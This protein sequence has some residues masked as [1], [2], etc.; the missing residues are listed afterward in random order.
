MNVAEF[1]LKLESEIK[2]HRVRVGFTTEKNG[3][4]VGSGE[5]ICKAA[6][7]NENSIPFPL[8]VFTGDDSDLEF[9]GEGENVECLYSDNK[10]ER[11]KMKFKDTDNNIFIRIE[12]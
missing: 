7:C 2:V 9:Y 11:Y 12:K 10:M 8:V 5:I 6:G 3:K 1:F 4:I